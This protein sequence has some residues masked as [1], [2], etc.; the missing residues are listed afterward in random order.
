MGHRFV[1]ID[2][3]SRFLMEAIRAADAIVPAERVFVEEG[4]E[5]AEH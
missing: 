2:E 3:R 5:K 4:P 1:G